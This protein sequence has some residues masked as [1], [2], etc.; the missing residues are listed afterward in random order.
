MIRCLTPRLLLELQHESV[1]RLDVH[2]SS[3]DSLSD[4]FLVT[5]QL[6]DGAYQN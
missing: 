4:M 2:M 5:G 6:V 1:S 3:E